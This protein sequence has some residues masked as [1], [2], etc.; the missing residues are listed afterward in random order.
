[1][2]DMENIT[3]PEIIAELKNRLEREYAPHAKLFSELAFEIWTFEMDEHYG[4]A[5]LQSR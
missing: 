4:K 1:M 2:Q 5:G 3:T